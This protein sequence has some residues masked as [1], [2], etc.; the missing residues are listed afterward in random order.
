MEIDLYNP[1]NVIIFYKIWKV[2]KIK[3]EHE[4]IFY[5]SQFIINLIN[6]S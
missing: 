5:K 1:Q 6:E 2:N 3:F 4:K